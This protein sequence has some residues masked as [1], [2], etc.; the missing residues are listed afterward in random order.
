M[1]E[2]EIAAYVTQLYADESVSGILVQLP[3]PGHINEERI[4]S[5]IGPDKDVDGLHPINLANLA[6]KG[7]QPSF[8][9]C[10]PFGCMRLIESV[11]PE[12][13]EGLNAA[14]IGRSAIVGVPMAMLL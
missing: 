13:I 14:V 5:L 2:E 9:A 12:G 7:K 3:L 4:L 6:V 10:T 8:V 1:S 11:R